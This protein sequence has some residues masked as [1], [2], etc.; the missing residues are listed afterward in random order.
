MRFSALAVFVVAL[1]SFVFLGSTLNT[2][3]NHK[4]LGNIVSRVE[5]KVK[6]FESFFHGEKDKN[7][8]TQDSPSN[9][10]QW[11]VLV[12]GSNGYYNYRHQVFH[13]L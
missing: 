4:F 5:E 9:P 6:N 1:F 10:K 12:A 11:A 3:N 13:S 7:V 8:D 2:N